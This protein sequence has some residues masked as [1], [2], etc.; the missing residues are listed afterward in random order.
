MGKSGKDGND[1]EVEA[2][3]DLGN[4]ENEESFL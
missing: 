2:N 3:D 4:K 1:A